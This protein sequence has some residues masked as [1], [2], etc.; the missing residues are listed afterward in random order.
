ML[1]PD[2]IDRRQHGVGIGNEIP[3][4][5]LIDVY[6]NN[7][8]STLLDLESQESTRGANLQ[9]PLSREIV[10]SEIFV[11]F[12]TQIPL[13]VHQAMTGNIHRVI[14]IALVCAL[15]IPRRNENRTIRSVGAARRRDARTGTGKAVTN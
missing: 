14:E 4:A 2:W 9:D 7:F 11:G 3:G 8:G 1:L 15:H 12:A 6:R 13:A 10:I 5:I